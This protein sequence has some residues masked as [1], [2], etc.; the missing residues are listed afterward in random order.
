MRTL[1]HCTLCTLRCTIPYGVQCTLYTVHCTLYT[2]L[3]TLF[4]N[5]FKYHKYPKTLHV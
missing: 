4:L 3:Y 1:Q 5:D 2:V